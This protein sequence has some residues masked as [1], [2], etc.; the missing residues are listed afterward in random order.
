MNV[1]GVSSAVN[2]H[3][4]QQVGNNDGHEQGEDDGPL[5]Q[6][7]EGGRRSCR[8]IAWVGAAGVIKGRW[9]QQGGL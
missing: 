2:D 6:P 1:L 8:T 9:H 5:K 4:D 7:S 3:N